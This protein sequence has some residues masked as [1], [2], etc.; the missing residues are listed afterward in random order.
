MNKKTEFPI[1]NRVA[2]SPLITFDL[3]E[4]YHKGERVLFDIKD[5]L[6]EGMI[7]KEKE[8]RAK[9]KEFDWSQFDGKN[10]AITCSEDA[11]IPTWAYMLI[12]TR[13]SPFAHMIVFGNL[14]DLDSAL[15]KQALAD[16][17]I[18]KYRD[19]KVVVKGCGK[20]PVPESAYVEITRLLTPVVSSIMYGEPCSTVP[21]Y[22][23]SIKK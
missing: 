9:V 16:L 20:Y 13:L 19:K 11:I 23:K 12:A 21:L 22:K 1:I 8:F 2:N 6:F 5:F 17:D 18:E 15:Y 10:V 7:L 4:Y 14:E 3:E